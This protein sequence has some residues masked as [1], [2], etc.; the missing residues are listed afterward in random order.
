MKNHFWGALFAL[1]LGGLSLVLTPATADTGTGSHQSVQQAESSQ[2][3]A[4]V[5]Q[6]PENSAGDVLQKAS[7]G[8]AAVGT[9]AWLTIAGKRR[10]RENCDF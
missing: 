7:L 8:A 2:D 9:G 4:Q 6:T 1:I 10:F 5:Q 3:I